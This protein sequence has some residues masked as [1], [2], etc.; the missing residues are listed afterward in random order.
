[1]AAPEFAPWTMRSSA[2]SPSG[3]ATKV[4]TVPARAPREGTERSSGPASG[5]ARD[6]MG[7]FAASNRRTAAGKR[8][9]MRSTLPIPRSRRRP[10]SLDRARTS[11]PSPRPRKALL[12]LRPGQDSASTGSPKASRRTTIR[13]SRRLRR[14]ENRFRIGSTASGPGLRDPLHQPEAAG[15]LSGSV[16]SRRAQGRFQGCADATRR[17]SRPARTCANRGSWRFG[18]ALPPRSRPG[19]SARAPAQRER[20]IGESGCRRPRSGPS[21]ACSFDSGYSCTRTLWVRH[22]RKSQER[23]RRRLPDPAQLLGFR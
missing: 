7:P 12:P 14:V 23:R 9:S 21:F 15:S 4:E 22:E 2:T 8:I 18:T 20:R 6:L 17:S 16:L 10:R 19:A 11:S 13:K 5:E 1:M 3:S